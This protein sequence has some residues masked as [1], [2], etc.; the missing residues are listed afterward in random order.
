MLSIV[1]ETGNICVLVEQVIVF[2]TDM[3]LLILLLSLLTFLVH[4]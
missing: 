4:Y 3:V 1:W 2:L